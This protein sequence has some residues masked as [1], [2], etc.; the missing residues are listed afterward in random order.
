MSLNL[1]GFRTHIAVRHMV[2][3]GHVRG[4]NAGIQEGE[5]ESDAWTM[6]VHVAT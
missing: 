3:E 1:T 4:F 5:S 2:I 6:S